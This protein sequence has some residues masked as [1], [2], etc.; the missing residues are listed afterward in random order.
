M[1]KFYERD[2]DEERRTTPVQNIIIVSASLEEARR[3]CEAAR[4]PLRGLGSPRLFDVRNWM[5]NTEKLHGMQGGLIL[6]TDGAMR[7]GINQDFF[8]RAAASNMLVMCLIEPQFSTDRVT[9]N[10]QRLDINL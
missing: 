2:E 6:I 8:V 10:A 5:G 1:T 4:W 3:I 9:F 7:Y